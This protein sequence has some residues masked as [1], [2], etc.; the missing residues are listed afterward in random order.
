[1]VADH[2]LVY[3]S[4]AALSLATSFS[5]QLPAFSAAYGEQQQPALP[6]TLPPIPLPPYSAT[7]VHTCDGR[8]DEQY[9]A[10]CEHQPRGDLLPASCSLLLTA[11]PP[12]TAPA[13]CLQ[14]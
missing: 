9:R 8:S 2:K 10:D 6:G 3:R 4:T 1:M 13:R 11:R 12:S 7:A 14:A 5:P